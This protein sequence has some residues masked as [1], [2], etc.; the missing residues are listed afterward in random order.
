M[1][2]FLSDCYPIIWEI[3]GNGHTFIHK[4]SDIVPK[5][6]I[7]FLSAPCHQHLYV[8]GIVSGT[9]HIQREMKISSYLLR[10]HSSVRMEDMYSIHTIENIM[11]CR[12]GGHEMLWRDITGRVT[13]VSRGIWGYWSR[14]SK[15]ECEFTRIQKW[16]ATGLVYSITQQYIL[17]NKYSNH[18]RFIFLALL[19]FLLN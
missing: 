4:E 13:N 16:K 1:R 6:I 12:P 18:T 5:N 17:T 8:S 15:D 19:P 2:L 10:V 7:A 14:V 11:W 3:T 9:G